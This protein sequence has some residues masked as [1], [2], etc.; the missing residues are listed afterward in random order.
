MAY[1][2]GRGRRTTPCQVALKISPLLR[3][4]SVQRRGSAASR[5]GTASVSEPFGVSMV[6]RKEI[7]SPKTKEREV[8]GAFGARGWGLGAGGWVV[9]RSQAR[10]PSAERRVDP[11]HVLRR[12]QRQDRRQHEQRRGRERHHRDRRDDADRS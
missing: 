8:S 10:L 3:P 5:G 12:S 7:V 9:I 1:E 11:F 2:I 6:E 4:W